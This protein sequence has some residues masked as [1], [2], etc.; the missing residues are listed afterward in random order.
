MS[1]HYEY[2]SLGKFIGTSTPADPRAEEIKA[3][4]Q[5]IAELESVLGECLAY[6]ENRSDVIDGDYGFPAP[7]AEMRMLSRLDE[8][9]ADFAAGLEPLPGSDTGAYS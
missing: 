4:Y 1:I 9:L 5:R 7:N 8:A 2:P 3:A 6:F